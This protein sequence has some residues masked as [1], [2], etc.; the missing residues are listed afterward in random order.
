MAVQNEWPWMKGRAV[1]L[2][3]TFHA[4]IMIST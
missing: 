4:S 2:G 1:S 3:L